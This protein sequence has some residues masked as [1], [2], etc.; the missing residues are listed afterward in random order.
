[1]DLSLSVWLRLRISGSAEL[2]RL[3]WE[4]RIASDGQGDHDCFVN[5]L[6]IPSAILINFVS[7]TAR[8]DDSVG[9][10]QL[11]PATVETSGGASVLDEKML[12][13]IDTVTGRPW[14]YIS[15]AGSTKGTIAEKWIEIG[16]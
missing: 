1:M 3:I 13:K 9:R 4:P 11:V 8:A 15:T 7:Y 10:F 2:G 12:F 6:I 16:E 14:E 5:A